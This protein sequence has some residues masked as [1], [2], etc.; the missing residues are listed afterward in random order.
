M[1]KLVGRH[2]EQMILQEA[3]ASKEAEFIAIYGRRRI[4]KTFLIRHFF[5]PKTFFIEITGLK[6]GSMQEQLAE[7]S[8]SFALAFPSYPATFKLPNW[9]NAFEL[10]TAQLK[11]LPITKKITVFFDEV[12]WLSTPRSAFL[13]ALDFF[14]NREWSQMSN[15]KV[16]VCGSAASWIIKNLI[17]AKGGLHNR[18]TRTL[19]LDPFTLSESWAYLKA[20]GISLSHHQIVEL[21]MVLGGV[22]H[23]LSQIP[24]GLSA[25]QAVNRLCFQETGAL[26][27][28]FNKLF[29]SL[30]YHSDR[31]IHLIQE[32]AKVRNGISRKNL[33]ERLETGSGRA[34]SA[35]LSELEEAGFI[36]SFIPYGHQKKE[37]YYRIID[38]Y[39]HF[40]L[41]W[42]KG[43]PKGIFSKSDPH[44]WNK[45]SG[46]PAW[47]SWA[48]YAF[49]S[50]CYKHISQIQNAL[51]LSRISCEIGAWRYIPRKGSS[52]KGAQIDLLFDRRDGIISICE[53]KYSEGEFVI[54]KAYAEE[55]KYKME[56]FKTHARTG[57]KHLF[58]V[59]VTR[60]GVRR[61]QYYDELVSNE[62]VVEN[63]FE[64]AKNEDG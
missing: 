11:Q 22:P 58:L 40:Y 28:E 24:K 17:Y 7:F 14:W 34:L 16:I 15:L 33:I 18:L 10:L 30:F 43:A 45:K 1:K 49:E 2:R 41:K 27:G 20:R 8:R 37:V 64:L 63:L 12:P 54:D 6:D 44:Y 29:S 38:E 3:L 57:K 61:N 36:A 51:G 59:M 35:D 26:Y 46:S 13:Q 42:I 48:G 31:H 53:L 21:Y 62:V 32:I 55:L 39:S 56:N 9:R 50:L 19:R 5:Q 23:Y 4:G 25:H 60:C 47:R 52:D